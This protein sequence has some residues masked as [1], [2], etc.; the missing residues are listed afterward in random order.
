MAMA[1]LQCLLG[2]QP[3]LVGSACLRPCMRAYACVY[4]C[5]CLG[6]PGHACLQGGEVD[7]PQQPL[8]HG[9]VPEL[10]VVAQGGGVPP[11]MVWY[12]MLA[13][14]IVPEK[15][16]CTTCTEAVSWGLLMGAGVCM[17]WVVHAA[18]WLCVVQRSRAGNL[19]A[20]NDLNVPHQS[21]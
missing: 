16:K 1:L 8:V 3:C 12:G 13:T 20:V 6:S 19:C 15:S 18:S 11:A 21:L 17:M 10:P 4:V 2:G 5:V 14:S 9:H 7:V